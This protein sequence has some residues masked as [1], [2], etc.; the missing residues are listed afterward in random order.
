MLFGYN[1]R[2]PLIPIDRGTK[3]DAHDELLDR[4]DD[5]STNARAYRM[6]F[7]CFFCSVA[8]FAV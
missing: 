2:T 5:E 1:F 8:V 7:A 4:V 6:C 3:D